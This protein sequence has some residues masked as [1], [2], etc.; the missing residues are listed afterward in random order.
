MASAGVAVVGAGLAGSLLALALA[1]RGVATTLVGAAAPSATALSYGGMAG[2]AI[3]RQWQALERLHGP[4]GWRPSRLVLHGWPEPLNRL[5]P[6]LQALATAVVPLSRVDAPALAAALPSALAAAGV[7]RQ[8]AAVKRLAPAGG[9]WE[10]ALEGAAAIEA[11]QVVLAAGAG[12]R[13]LW[14]ELP[15]R[16]RFSWAGVIVVAGGGSGGSEPK[17]QEPASRGPSESAWLEQAR[18]GRIVQ[19]R[20]WRRSA[21]EATAAELQQER[22]IVDAGLAPW[23]ENVLLGQISLVGPNADP[24]RPPDPATMEARLRQGLAELDPQL[25]ALAGDYRQVPVPFCSDGQPLAGP[26]AGAPPG[27]W[28]FSGFSGAFTA[29]PPLAETLAESVAASLAGAADRTNHG[30]TT[31]L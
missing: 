7:A 2:R 6:P 22:W 17:S 31:P 18:L 23:G 27:L 28:A 4:L 21:L 30:G 24:C 14:P 12:C 3:A 8:E 19:A 5:P 1:R 10:L 20:Q 16:L 15:E 11:R 29:V 9:G 13:D 25:A 26:V